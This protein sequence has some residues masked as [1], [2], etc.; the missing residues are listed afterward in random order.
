MEANIA[1]LIHMVGGI[2]IGVI[3]LA[4][5]SYFFSSIGL[6]PSQEDETES[7]EQLAKF[8]LEYEIYDKKGMYGVDVI[9]CLNKAKSN[10][11]KYAEGGSFLTGNKYG[12]NFYVD[13]YVR[14]TKKE[15]LEE[16]V[17]V[18]YIDKGVQ[19]QFFSNPEDNSTKVK[20]DGNALTMGSKDV[21]FFDDKFNS[22]DWYTTF[23][24]DTPIENKSV[25]IT[26]S[27]LKG[28]VKKVIAKDK[29]VHSHV[30]FNGR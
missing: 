10:N 28:N 19:R 25:L 21:K 16:S 26:E 30:G 4:L 15:Y 9:S 14:L 20:I 29:G 7:R 22:N 3:L 2:L 8:N 5:I 24:K 11:E 12:E 13:V 23:N 17:E 6:L 18:Y 1:K 27:E